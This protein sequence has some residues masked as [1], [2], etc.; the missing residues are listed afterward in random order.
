M[1]KLPPLTITSLDALSSAASVARAEPVRD[2]RRQRGDVPR[3]HPQ[4]LRPDRRSDHAGGPRVRAPRAGAAR[5]LRRAHRSVRRRDEAARGCL[6]VCTAAAEVSIH[7][8]V[9]ERLREVLTGIDARFARV[10]ALAK[11]RGELPPLLDP[12]VLAPVLA[13]V[14]HTLAVRA[15][16]DADREQLQALAEAAVAL[17]VPR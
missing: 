5:H 13:G 1:C 2:V 15:R 14:T 10:L 6:I 4:L 11:Q 8:E 16:A 17:V 9:R 7:D 3:G 12:E